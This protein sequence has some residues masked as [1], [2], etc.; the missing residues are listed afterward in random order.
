MQA[1]GDL[2]KEASVLPADGQR[3]TALVVQG[4]GLRGVYSMGALA[5]LEAQGLGNAFDVVVGSSAGAINAAYFLAG[6]AEEAVNVYVD[7]LSNKKFVNPL[8]VHRVVDIDYMVDV[9]LKELC[10]LRVDLVQKSQTLLEVVVT[11]SETAQPCVLTNRDDD[12]DFYELIRATAAL[13]GLYDQ[14][15]R[16]RGRLYVDGGVV[17]GVPVIYAAESGATDILTV[18]TRPPGFRRLDTSAVMR[19]LSRLLARR[20]S[21]AVR[22]KIGKEDALFNKAMDLLEGIDRR[23]GINA[24]TVWPSDESRL[25]GRTTSDRSRLLDCAEMGREDMRRTLKTDVAII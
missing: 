8:R 20:Q 19:Y 21:T 5:E 7:F 13:P 23:E 3:R 1:I 2:L 25:V 9:V 22:D 10:P 17:D 16:L 11:D 15:V 6:Q 12:V 4:G 14:K 18:V 24:W